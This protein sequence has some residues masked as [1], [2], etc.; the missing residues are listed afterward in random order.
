[1][2][3][4]QAINLQVHVRIR[5]EGIGSVSPA[6]ILFPEKP[7]GGRGRPPPHRVDLRA[8]PVSPA[9]VYDGGLLSGSVP[10]AIPG[11]CTRRADTAFFRECGSSPGAVWIQ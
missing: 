1:V 3:I 9:W 6:Q 4:R 11:W 7:A 2:G 10:G 5:E 8:V